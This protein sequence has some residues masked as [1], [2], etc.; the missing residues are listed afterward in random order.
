MGSLNPFKIF[1][2]PKVDNSALL[3]Q[4]EEADKREKE[5]AA[6]EKRIEDEEQRRKQAEL[7]A[8]RGG[9]AGRTNL[10]VGS[11]TGVAATDEKRRSLG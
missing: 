6:E 8:R 1:S 11:E 5:I 10:L 7:N 4:Q 3:R 2:K 9:R